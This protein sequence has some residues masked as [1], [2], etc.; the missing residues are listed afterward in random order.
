MCVG[1]IV[2]LFIAGV[3][4]ACLRVCACERAWLFACSFTCWFVCLFAR[5]FVRSFRR[6]F[7]RVFGGMPVCLFA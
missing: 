5:L 7:S 4:H 2:C 6:S 3:M 1:V